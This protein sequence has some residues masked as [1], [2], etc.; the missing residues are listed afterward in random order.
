MDNVVRLAREFR[1]D[2]VVQYILHACHTYEIE[3]INVAAALKDAGVPSLK[4]ETDYA[5]EDAA[6]WESGSRPSSR[7]WS[8]RNGG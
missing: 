6:A 1:A 2:G 3:A 4:I 7:A 8:T 5:E